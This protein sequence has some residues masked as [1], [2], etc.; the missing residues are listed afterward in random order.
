MAFQSPALAPASRRGKDLLVPRGSSLPPTCIKCSAAATTPWRKKFYW[1]PPWVF[2]LVLLNLLIYAVVAIIIRKKMELNVPLC[3]RHHADRK[4]NR[5]LGILMIA[6]CVP[7]GLLFGVY[8]SG[9]LGWVTGLAMFVAS[10]VF[11]VLAS[12]GF[13]PTRIDDAGG[14]FRGACEDFLS[15]L[16][17]QD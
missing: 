12:M 2:I 15:L 13:R 5:L 17:A 1:H 11:F 16:P 9:A 8:G 3:D 10:V 7:A 6:G 4:R 14:V